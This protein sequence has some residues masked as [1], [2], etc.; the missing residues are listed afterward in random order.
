MA[1]P[2]G[3]TVQGIETQL[4][5]NHVGHFVLTN[6]LLPALAKSPGA[7]VVTVSSALH[8]RGRGARLLETLE[9]DP[10]FEQRRYVPFD[11]YGDAKLANI[12]FSKALARRAPSVLSLSLHPGVIPTNLTR[13]MGFAGAAFRLLGAPFMKSVQQGAA[14]TIYA[15]TAPELERASGVY[16]SDCA[17]AEPSREAKDTELGERLWAATERFIAS[18]T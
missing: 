5:T 8:K 9:R 18:R 6:G 17:I 7:R 4:G 3:V 16:L 11:A 12:L 1:T 14:T 2:L 15:A 13:S 10:R